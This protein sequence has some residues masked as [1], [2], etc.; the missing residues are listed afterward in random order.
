MDLRFFGRSKSVPEGTNLEYNP[1]LGIE[2][3]AGGNRAGV[4]P[5]REA[6]QIRPVRVNT[7]SFEP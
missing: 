2:K 4:I 1:G 7:E 3:P 5:R 6:S